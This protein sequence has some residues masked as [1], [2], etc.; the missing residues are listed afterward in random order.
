VGVQYA[1]KGA[2]DV[3]V[4]LQSWLADVSGPHQTA[5]PQVPPGQ[6]NDPKTWTWKSAFITGVGLD[7]L[8]FTFDFD[9]ATGEWNR[10]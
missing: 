4:F 1:D 3:N 6:W 2:Y 9:P 5:K 8:T 10:K 7:D